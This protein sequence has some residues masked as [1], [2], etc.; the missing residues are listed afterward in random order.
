MESRGCIGKS[1]WHDMPLKGSIMGLEGCFPFIIFGYAYE[2]I[3][4]LKIKFSIDVSG[5]HGV[6]E[7]RN[8]WKGV[9]VF[10][11]YLV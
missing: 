9:T 8:E 5:A 11:G 3:S 10:L 1:K 6:K 4:M 7:I 2:I